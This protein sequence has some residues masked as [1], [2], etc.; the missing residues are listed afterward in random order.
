MNYINDKNLSEDSVVH[1]QFSFYLAIILGLYIV[2][3][4]IISIFFLVYN[5]LDIILEQFSRT[6]YI[7][8]YSTKK[9][10]QEMDQ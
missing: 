7:N 3:F 1:N 6:R 2:L 9:S 5:Q 4:P 10:M 8:E